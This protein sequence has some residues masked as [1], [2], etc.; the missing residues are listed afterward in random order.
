MPSQHPRLRA[1]S[2]WL[3]VALAIL[4]PGQAAAQDTAAGT[5]I[6]AIA[7][8]GTMLTRS[9]VEQ[10]IAAL[11][12]ATD[13]P[14]AERDKLAGEL[15]AVLEDLTD[16]QRFEAAAADYAAA[17]KQAPAETDAI[18]AELALAEQ[19]RAEPALDLPDEAD[20][21]AVEARIA[22]DQVDIAGIEARIAKLSEALEAD[23]QRPA[24][25][26]ARVAAID[27]EL[28]EL[29]STAAGTEALSDRSRELIDWQLQARRA[30][31]RAEQQMLEQ[32]LLS[33]DARRQLILAQRE[34]ERLALDRAKALRKV[35]EARADA[36]RKAAAAAVQESLDAERA[37]AADAHP[38][39]KTWVER[40]AELGQAIGKTTAALDQ[41][42][43]QHAAIEQETARIDQEFANARE[44]L[45]AAGLNRAQ[46]Q[47]LIDQRAHLPDLRR[48]RRKAA[49][50]AERIADSTLA[51]IRW[52]EEL[53]RMDDLDIW[54]QEQLAALP[55]S[56]L[57]AEA[58]TQILDDLRAQ[59]ES[60]RNLL[61][62]ALDMDD[63]YRRALGEVDFAA[64]HLRKVTQGYNRYLSERLLWVRSISPIAKQSF[65][66]LPAALYWL[67]RP[68]HWATVGDTLTTEA[69]RSAAL[70][71]GLVAVAVLLWRSPALR[72]AIRASAEPLRRI[73]TDR[74]R[75]TLTALGLTMVASAP[76]P[77]LAL[78]LG[79]VL[80]GSLA[81]SPFTKAL[82]DALM[83]IVPALCFLIA[84]R[85][86]CM[87]GGVADRHF[88]WRTDTLQLMRRSAWSA[89]TLL[90]P[91]GL[92]AALV[93]SHQD[94]E[95]TGTL[96]R[97]SLALF[98]IGFAVLTALVLHP[99]RGAMKHLLAERPDGWL[100]RLRFIWYPATVAVPL[101][102]AG[103]ALAGFLYTSRTLLESLLNE[104]WLALGLMVAHQLIARWLLV[105]RR[106]LALQA[107]LER[108]AQR[109][110]AK[111]AAAK[112]AEA[113]A[114]PEE[115]VDLV[116]LDTQTRKL[117]NLAIFVAAVVGLWLIW[118]DVLPALN[119][120]ERVTLWSYTGTV[121]GLEQSIP[122]TLADVGLV[123]V[124]IA[125]AIAAASNLPAL[126]EILLLQNN[127]I[128]AGSRYTI[129]TLTGYTIVAIGALMVFNA[130]GLSWGQVQWLVAALGVG[131]GF[132]LQEIVA[133][134]ISGII[135]LFER[136]VRVGDIVTIGDTDGVVTRIQIRA[137]TVRNWDRKELLV[138]NKELITGRVINWT[139]SDQVNRIVIPVGV[140][141]GSDTRK[142][143][144]ILGEVARENEHVVDDPAPLISFEG[145][146]N[147][148]LTLVLRC[149]LQTMDYR[150]DTITA[151]H[152]AIDDRFR[153]AG[154]GIAFPQRDIHL[155]SSEPLEVCLHRT[156]R[157]AGSGGSAAG[158][159]DGAG[160]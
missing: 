148:A 108:R 144:R 154:I 98:E 7:A 151:L 75:Y 131:I 155:R 133:N 102:L 79:Q 45:E 36:L 142:A 4:L 44:R 33:A 139:L 21:A 110:A 46:G 49:V 111:A 128:T 58:R 107:A 88:R 62:T 112:G 94:P 145:F 137:T 103:L 17:I 105:T 52:R 27:S 53:R 95:L 54:L 127:A 78:T 14:E 13:L 130:L 93:H 115:A 83:A 150:I 101:A 100:N 12:K 19:T 40:N 25:I 121:N 42:D 65:V 138:P 81:A 91:V 77:L 34:R 70:W 5:A 16:A 153:A 158:A 55:P 76:W 104:L 18:R 63:S 140:E 136:P 43:E 156:E 11:D 66:S 143:L 38:L 152:Q 61:R 20:L 41:L 26:R 106:R 126:L 10:R 118:S 159:G 86:L 124:I 122:V 35:L 73:S 135:I 59:A 50:R 29:D 129:I 147:D 71:L 149:Y 85:M 2:R 32:Q 9:L 84:F 60:R 120:F 92:V 80:S 117:L 123:L 89:L 68:D 51:S 134:F 56:A 116:A 97:L 64:Q 125:A 22:A 69:M 15:N 37:A 119:L 160:D 141:Y 99:T 67:V 96:G 48:L 157:P 90:L 82:G 57:S 23:D 146:G 113:L 47:V 87:R 8:N 114:V 132:G 109:E 74:F 30:L 1:L 28:S 31:L 6:T 24:K 72:R 39:V 3:C